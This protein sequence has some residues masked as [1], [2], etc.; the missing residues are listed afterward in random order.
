VETK[1]AQPARDVVLAEVW[2]GGKAKAEV[3]WVARL[4]RDRAE[5]VS[6]LTAAQTCHTLQENLVVK[7][8]VPT[9]GR[10]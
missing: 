10:E 1:Q 8:V 5:I 2:V 7:R 6:A 4:R 3:E 9:A